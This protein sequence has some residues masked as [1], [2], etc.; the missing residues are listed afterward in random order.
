MEHCGKTSVKNVIQTAAENIVRLKLPEPAKWPEIKGFIAEIDR[1][2]MM[3]FLTKP[4]LKYKYVFF[5]DPTCGENLS[6][7]DLIFFFV[8]DRQTPSICS[9]AT[10]TNIERCIKNTA[11]KDGDE[12]HST[13]NTSGALTRYV[14]DHLLRIE[15]EEI[16]GQNPDDQDSSEDIT[17]KVLVQDILKLCNDEDSQRAIIRLYPPEAV[18]NTYLPSSVCQTL[19]SEIDKIGHCF[20]PGKTNISP[21]PELIKSFKAR[22]E[23]KDLKTL[24]IER[25]KISITSHIERLKDLETSLTKLAS[26]PVKYQDR[27]EEIRLIKIKKQELENELVALYE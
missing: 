14:S 22:P 27:I 5:K 2:N 8:W 21:T 16:V 12:N 19:K 23:D 9:Y 10:I 24:N 7:G 11:W 17:Y 20:K 4:T 6:A 15:F 18:G 25:L 1:V 13:F 3:L 26:D